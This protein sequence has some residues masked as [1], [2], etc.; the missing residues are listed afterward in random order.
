M[1]GGDV[2]VAQAILNARGYNCGEIDGDF[3]IKTSN[4]VMAFQGESGLVID[5][6]VGPATWKALG[7]VA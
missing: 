4:M 2:A 1:K 3:G 7:V 5:G 6:I